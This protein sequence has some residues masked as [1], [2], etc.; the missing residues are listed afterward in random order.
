MC[1]HLVACL[2][3]KNKISRPDTLIANREPGRQKRIGGA[4]DLNDGLKIG[5]RSVKRV[6][7]KPSSIPKVAK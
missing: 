4:L 5:A 3:M 6:K 7:T 1:E 2:I